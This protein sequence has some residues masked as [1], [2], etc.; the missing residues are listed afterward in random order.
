VA[1]CAR[2]V[3]CDLQQIKGVLSVEGDVADFGDCQRMFGEVL[4]E[5]G[6]LDVM[7]NNAAAAHVGYF[8]DMQPHEWR[9]LVD[10]NLG[11]VINLS[12][13]A[14]RQMLKQGSGQII[15]ISS[16]WGGVGA[17]CE[18]VYSAT[19]GG[20]NAF[21]RALA[22][23]LGP[24]GIRVNAV[25]C[26]IVDTGMNDFLDYTEILELKKQIPLGRFAKPF[27]IASVV[28]NLIKFEYITGQIITIDGGLT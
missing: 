22:K 4:R 27:E 5:F 10:V 13:L 1:F 8:A 7:V 17:S 25:A 26:G 6:G 3:L 11:G 20:V 18:A 15:N 14:A 19:K 16:I 24:A 12:N 9:R 23:E 28:E 2:N 21:T